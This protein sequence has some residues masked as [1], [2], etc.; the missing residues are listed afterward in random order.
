[1]LVQLLK[2]KSHVVSLDGAYEDKSSIKMVLELCAGGE[3]FDRI[4]SKKHYS[5]KDAAAIVRQMLEVVGACHMNGII[6]RDLK[7]ENFLFLSGEDDSELKVT[8]FGLSTF[9]RS[10]QRFTEVIG[11]AYYIAPEVLQRGYGPQCDVWSIGV[12][13]YITLCGR[14]PFFGRTESAVFGN[15]M[16]AK[17]RLDE[18]FKRDPW[19]KISPEAKDLITKMLN[20]TFSCTQARKHASTRARTPNF[21][22]KEEEKKQMNVPRIHTLRRLP[23][24]PI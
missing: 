15:I 6:H 11:S 18:N 21:T 10:G 16:K 5:E 24:L 2:G 19:P 12:I 1:M 4:I 7:P 8:D 14:P 17:T 9:Y 22:L 13:M 20:G 3:L 23:S